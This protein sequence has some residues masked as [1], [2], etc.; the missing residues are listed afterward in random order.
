M[1][2]N[3]LSR[4]AGTYLGHKYP[5]EESPQGHEEMLN[6]DYNRDCYAEQIVV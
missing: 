1:A 2:A 4:R 6:G 5:L 3:K